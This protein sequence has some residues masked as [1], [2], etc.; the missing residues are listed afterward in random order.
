MHILV[1]LISNESFTKQI[2]L[3]VVVVGLIGAE[4]QCQFINHVWELDPKLYV[5]LY[6]L[7]A[8][9]NLR[10]YIT[11]CWADGGQLAHFNISPDRIVWNIVAV[12][13]KTMSFKSGFI[14]LPQNKPNKKLFFSLKVL[15]KNGWTATGCFC[16]LLSMSVGA[17]LRLMNVLNN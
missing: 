10:K 12:K 4:E 15:F 11:G 9:T 1:A 3:Y 14:A 17:S 7:I 16:F 13:K 2:R 6:T 8:N 5:Q